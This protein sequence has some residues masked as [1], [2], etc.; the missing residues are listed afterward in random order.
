MAAIDAE[1]LASVHQC[2]IETWRQTFGKAEKNS[3][4]ALPHKG[5]VQKARAPQNYSV[6]SFKAIVQVW[7]W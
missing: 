4:I 7:G 2:Q 6:L 1:N 3:F 5:G